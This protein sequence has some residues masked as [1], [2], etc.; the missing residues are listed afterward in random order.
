MIRALLT[1]TLLLSSLVCSAAGPED[2]S[3]IWR[4]EKDGQV[5]YLLGT[6]HYLPFD[7][8]EFP[9][10]VIELIHSSRVFLGELKFNEVKAEDEGWKNEIQIEEGSLENYLSP[11]AKAAFEE[12]FPSE[13][14][15]IYKSVLPGAVVHSAIQ[16]ARERMIF[17]VNN[18]LRD[19]FLLTAE[20]LSQKYEAYEANPFLL[21]LIKNYGFPSNFGLLTELA[22]KE[23]QKQYIGV[24]VFVQERADEKGVEIV[25]LDQGEPYHHPIREYVALVDANEMNRALLAAAVRS[26]PRDAQRFMIDANLREDLRILYSRREYFSSNQSLENYLRARLI[27]ES[28][29]FKFNNLPGLE[30]VN[31]YEQGRHRYWI[32]RI[33]GEAEKGGAFIAADL[34]HI[35]APSTVEN[36]NLIDLLK[37]RGFTVTRSRVD[38]NCEGKLTAKDQ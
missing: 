37:Q 38:W 1:L 24:D 30:R 7:Q 32:D 10:P 2:F 36:P 6:D 31:S 33:A 4:I 18:F 27:F 16:F 35:A 13:E 14:H 11:T 5:S 20:E 12:I 21:N 28:S 22:N 3:K 8:N 34:P 23:S 29:P 17:H 19:R 25:G 15:L 9:E 26:R